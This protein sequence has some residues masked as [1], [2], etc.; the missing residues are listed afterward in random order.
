MSKSRILKTFN[1]RK[2]AVQLNVY[3]LDMHFVVLLF[4]FGFGLF[5]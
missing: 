2:I 5:W 3:V 1:Y 4:Y